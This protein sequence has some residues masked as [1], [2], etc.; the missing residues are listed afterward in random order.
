MIPFEDS[1]GSVSFC[2]ISKVRNPKDVYSAG[3]VKLTY[4]LD[5]ETKVLYSVSQTYQEVSKGEEG[6]KSVLSSGIY[7]FKLMYAYTD[8]EEIVWEDEWDK[9]NACIPFEVKV[10]LSYPS[11]AEGQIVEFSETV[12]IPTGTLMESHTPES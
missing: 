11:Q 8:G 9:E 6:T 1:A 12:L 7:E 3:I 2:S 5:P 10:T 4:I